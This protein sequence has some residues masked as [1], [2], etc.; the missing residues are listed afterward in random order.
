MP[1]LLIEIMLLL[2]L[3]QSVGVSRK[4]ATRLQDEPRLFR[5]LGNNW[6]PVLRLGC[7]GLSQADHASALSILSKPVSSSI[8]M[9][10]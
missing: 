4:L 6:L 1:T 2:I 10:I 5:S 8:S 7:G 9:L 3:A